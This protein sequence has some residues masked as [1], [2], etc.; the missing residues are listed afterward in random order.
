MHQKTIREWR[1]IYGVL[2]FGGKILAMNFLLFAALLNFMTVSTVHCNGTWSN[3]RDV[4][5][6]EID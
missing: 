5:G 4:S 6:M 2:N 1:V 3:K